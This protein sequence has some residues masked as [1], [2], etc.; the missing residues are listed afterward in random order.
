M[1]QLVREHALEQLGTLRR[2][3]RGDPD[4]SVVLTAGPV[5]RPCDVAE[6][7]FRVQDRDD[8]VR[9]VFAELVAD[10]EKRGV[11]YLRSL[12]RERLLRTALEHHAETIVPF[13]REGV[14]NV[15]VLAQHL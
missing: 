2:T 14:M 7:L 8:G 4:A 3:G 6:P 5:G 9:G 12:R 13:L 1:R 15:G 10:S 11:E